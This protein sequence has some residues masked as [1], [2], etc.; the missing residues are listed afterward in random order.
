MRRSRSTCQTESALTLL[1]LSEFPATIIAAINKLSER[2]DFEQIITKGANG[3]VLVGKN[4]LLDRGVVFKFYYWHNGV[5]A[6]PN[7][8]A[9]LDNNNILKVEDA[10]AL[11]EEWAYFQTP[12]CGNGDID[13]FLNKSKLGPIEAIDL[14]SRIAS[15]VSYL[16]GEG[17]LHR[18]IKPSNIFMN[19]EWMPVIGDFGSV[20]EMDDTGV[21]NT[22]SKH[23]LI[24]RPPENITENVF[25]KQG[26]VYQIGLLLFQLLGGT[27]SYNERDWLNTSQA[28]K[29]DLLHG[30][31]RQDYAK[32]IIEK[33]IK[34]GKLINLKSL[35]C[36]VS[37]KTKRVIRRATNPDPSKRLKSCSELQSELHKLRAIELDWRID[38]EFII[39]QDASRK[40]RICLKQAYTVDK[41]VTA[42]WRSA[43][44]QVP[45]TLLQAVSYIRKEVGK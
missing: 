23:A 15:G 12:Y 19:N 9:S 25:S 24:Y 27:L 1:D 5:Y 13:D 38:D 41:K 16:H 45:C 36:W 10:A 18:D 21:V 4:K 29:Y 26:D 17:F 30:F 34:S 22:V 28:K 6:E 33:E 44:K 37:D 8:L 42:D 3:Y 31:E 7:K 35:P 43:F 32:G 14:T 40:F 11:D 2:F 20:A 39:L